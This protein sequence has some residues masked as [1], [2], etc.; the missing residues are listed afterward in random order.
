M[1]CAICVRPDSK[2]LEMNWVT[3]ITQNP[4]F[5]RPEFLP[6]GR[7][8]PETAAKW[9][10]EDD[11]RRGKEDRGWRPVEEVVNAGREEAGNGSRRQ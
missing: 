7:A 10:I 11:L 2:K 6:S 5:L 8:T 1:K 3:E 9:K 4:Y